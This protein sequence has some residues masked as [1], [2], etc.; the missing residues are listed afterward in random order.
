MMT[1]V[2]LILTVEWE[3]GESELN[4]ELEQSQ[5]ILPNGMIISNTDRPYL[6]PSIDCVMVLKRVDE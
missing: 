3:Y 2:V 6:A 1:K 5:I 4:N